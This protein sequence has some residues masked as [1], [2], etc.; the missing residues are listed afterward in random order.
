MKTALFGVLVL[1]LSGIAQAAPPTRYMVEVVRVED[2]GEK[3]ISV[4][5]F[6]VSPFGN[7]I[8]VVNE[9]FKPEPYGDRWVVARSTEGEVVGIPR[10]VAL[11][12]SHAYVSGCKKRRGKT[13]LLSST[14]SSSLRIQALD[15]GG[16]VIILGQAQDLVELTP[17][18]TPQ[19]CSVQVPKVQ[20]I[21]F[22]LMPEKDKNLE[23]T[24]Q[25]K[26]Q[27]YRV[28]LTPKT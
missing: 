16:R 10:A 2:Q 28:R 20:A 27:T 4:A 22:S 9:A 23:M 18:K 25:T 12:E 7:E 6:G 15:V 14:V 17:Y 5:D 19:G 3:V 1:L 8:A 24:V 11:E 21:D 26:I 13:E